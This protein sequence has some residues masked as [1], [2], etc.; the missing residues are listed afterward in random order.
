MSNPDLENDAPEHAG[1]SDTARRVNEIELRD[2][3]RIRERTPF[4]LKPVHVKVGAAVALATIVLAVVAGW[5]LGRSADTGRPAIQEITGDT[6]LTSVE[7]VAEGDRPALDVP[8]ESTGKKRRRVQG[9]VLPLPGAEPRPS[10]MV[11][12]IRRGLDEVSREA[13]EVQAFEW[14]EYFVAINC[15]FSCLEPYC[16]CSDDL[17]AACPE[18]EPAPAVPDEPE[19]VPEPAR[20]PVPE[21]VADP[22]PQPVPE[23]KPDAAPEPDAVSP[24]HANAEAEPADGQRPPA[25]AG[26]KLAAA[27][28]GATGP[29]APAQMEPPV[30]SGEPAG[31]SSP[32]PDGAVPEHRQADRKQAVEAARRQAP[33]KKPVPPTKYSVQIRSFKEEAIAKDFAREFGA[34]GYDTFVVSY[35]DP[36]GTTWFRV[37]TGHFSTAAEATAFAAGV[38]SKEAEQA[39]PVEAK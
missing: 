3:D 28:E 10:E 35:V 22:G 15:A 26:S 13:P 20:E 36:A 1:G 17:P 6:K 33:E 37:R 19:P 9:S 25:D 32:T 24:A 30:A 31:S 8:T 27:T 4:Q 16:A 18:P 14:W 7:A 5:M 12:T 34:K 11:E 39:I 29:Q 2:F 21:Q 23:T 38:N